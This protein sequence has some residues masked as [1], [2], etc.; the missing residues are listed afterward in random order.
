MINNMIIDTS[1]TGIKLVESDLQMIK[2]NTIQYSKGYAMEFLN[3]ASNTILDNAF[4]YN[5]GT[6]D[7]LDDDLVQAI[8]YKGGN[9][10]HDWERGNYWRDLE[11]SDDDQDGILDDTEYIID[12]SEGLDRFP[13]AEPSFP[14]ISK[15]PTNV[16]VKGMNPYIELTWED[17]G[18]GDTLMLPERYNIYRRPEGVEKYDLV[19]SSKEL[20]YQD[21][22]VSS[23]ITYLYAISSENSFGETPKSNDIPGIVD[24]KEPYVNI[25]TPVNGSVLSEPD[26]TIGW[27]ADDILGSI[28][29]LEL[30]IDEGNWIN[31]TG[32]KRYIAEDLDEGHHEV[33]LKAVDTAGNMNNSFSS[34]IIDLSPPRIL[35]IE[36]APASYLNTTDVEMV[37]SGMDDLSGPVHYT[38]RL[39]GKNISV[40]NLEGRVVLRD[41]SEGTHDLVVWAFDNG[42]HFT[43]FDF[44]YDIDLTPPELELE[45]DPAIT[46]NTNV[47]VSWSVSDSYSGISYVQ[48]LGPNSK[49]TNSDTMYSHVFGSDE[50]GVFPILVKAFDKA[51]NFKM[52]DGSVIFDF[53]APKI[54]EYGPTGSNISAYDLFQIIFDE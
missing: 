45:S 43:R 5:H 51:G 47:L 21:H 14:V 34:F 41:L 9:M 17:G 22:N 13:L 27:L 26:V 42:N 8:D 38:I 25:H 33:H 19:E 40:M 20:R 39:D 29:S 4:I 23:G 28:A 6:R 50:E 7:E 35:S 46:N 3:S 18:K 48:V 16:S 24:D 2:G 10:F 36:P 1:A 44:H 15:I 37:I 54:L 32:L 11:G 31:V 49:W 12:S 52:I 53:T 30:S